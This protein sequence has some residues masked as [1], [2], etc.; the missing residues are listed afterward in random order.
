MNK[1]SKI[2]LLAG[3][4]SI[5]FL[6]GCWLVGNRPVDVQ[7]I[8]PDTSELGGGTRFPNGISA[9]STSPS[10]GQIRGTS[11]TTTG[12]ATIGGAATLSSTVSVTATTTLSG[13]VL[14]SNSASS[15]VQIGSTAD[16]VGPGCLVLGDSASATSTPVYI[17]AT[18]STITGT[19]TKPAIC[20]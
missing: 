3:I 9:D 5:V 2:V 1:D 4:L 11:L 17:T 20:R 10:A 16:G 7:V 12:A 14:I 6:L 8:M 13:A 19:T 15:T 18:G